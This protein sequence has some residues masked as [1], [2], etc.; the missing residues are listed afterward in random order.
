MILFLDFVLWSVFV[1]LTGSILLDLNVR[2][3]RLERYFN[4]R[5]Q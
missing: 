3:I 4:D 2:I 1:A 5:D